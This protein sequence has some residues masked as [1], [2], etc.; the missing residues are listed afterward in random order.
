M[1]DIFTENLRKLKT[2]L[3][4]LISE[5]LFNHQLNDCEKTSGFV[6]LTSKILKETELH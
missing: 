1:L 4:T 5:K 3:E 6:L 2:F